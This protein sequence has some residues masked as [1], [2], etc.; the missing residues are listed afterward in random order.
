MVAVA[1]EDLGE[2]E[3]MDS[4]FMNVLTSMLDSLV[5]LSVVLVVVMGGLGR[6][7]H[8]MQLEAVRAVLVLLI[9]VMAV[10]AKVVVLFVSQKGRVVLVALVVL[11]G[12][13]EIMVGRGRQEE[14]GTLVDILDIR[15]VLL[16]LI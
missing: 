2:M 1:V 15:E 13:L 11:V 6:D 10:V 5:G 9:A 16:V 4:I 12:L 7:T 8:K 14:V 3:V